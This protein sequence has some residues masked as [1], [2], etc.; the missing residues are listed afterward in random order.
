MS[1]QIPETIYRVDPVTDDSDEILM[2]VAAVTHPDKLAGAIAK[3]LRMGQ[4]V[5]LRCCG[6]KATHQALRA[7]AYAGA[8]L[9]E[10]A[11]R[12]S[13]RVKRVAIDASMERFGFEI[14]V[15]AEEGSWTAQ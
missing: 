4:R 15:I 13:F 8:Y 14:V 2:R 5:T 9:E 6:A 3:C 1:N 11:I 10:D 7:L 12:L